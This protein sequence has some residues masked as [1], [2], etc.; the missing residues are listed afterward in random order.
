MSDRSVP[1]ESVGKN[2]Q[3]DTEVHHL[4][5]QNFHQ[6]HLPFQKYKVNVLLHIKREVTISG[7]VVF[8]RVE[9]DDI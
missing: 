5:Q 8:L 2:T 6:I 1:V 9:A 4:H 3:T 7:K